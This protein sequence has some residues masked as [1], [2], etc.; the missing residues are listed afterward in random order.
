MEPIF[1]DFY[2]NLEQMDHQSN[3]LFTFAEVLLN[4]PHEMSA[5]QIIGIY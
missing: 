1:V 5:I 2:E 3:V 4:I